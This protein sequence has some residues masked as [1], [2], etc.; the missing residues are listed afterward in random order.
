M[1]GFLKRTAST[2]ERF[3]MLAPGE[4][5]VV[6]LSG[7]P[8]SVCL[9]K[10]L[11]SLGYKPHAV[12]VDHGLRPDETGKEI[13]FCR[14]LCASLDVPFGVKSIDVRAYAKEHGMSIQE[15]GR[16]LRYKALDASAFEAK[17]GKIA[18]GHNLDDLIETFFINLLRGAGPKGLSSIPPVRGNIVRPLIER[19]RKEI[20]EFLDEEKTSYIVDSSNLKKDY[21]RNRVRL[22]LIPA[23][24]AL[25]PALS[26]T[27]SKTIG[28]LREEERYFDIAVTKTLMRLISR[29]KDMSIELFLAPLE[30]MDRVILRR[31]LR[32]VVDEV[33]G[34]REVSLLHIEDIIGL[35]QKGLPGD[36]LYLPK[37]VRVIKQYSTLLLTCEPPVRLGTYGLE[38]G[39][40]AVIKEA[41]ILIKATAV[42]LSPDVDGRTAIVLDADKTALPLTVR[43]RKPGDFFYPYG[44]GKRKKLQDFFV[45]EK[46][47]RDERDRVPIVTSR[48]DIV[49]VSGMRQDERYK[50]APGTKRFLLIETKKINL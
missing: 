38:P 45:D 29:K 16:R 1:S 50:A 4:T 31:V 30:T 48:E 46:V 8:D 12:Y 25:S 14:S 36:R 9:L 44:F 18:V 43:A 33:R 34:L 40:D 19:Q 26:G 23:L 21:L 24:K 3:A 47:P 42:D 11:K 27:L 35:I 6:G 7:G 10:S 37:G 41:G 20:E 28:I 32:R 17:A 39:S 49:W 13:D 2:I 22:T 15:A 5:V